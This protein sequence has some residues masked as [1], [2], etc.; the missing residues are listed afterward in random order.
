MFPATATGPG[1]GM[2]IACVA[3]RPIASPVSIVM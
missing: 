2:T 3:I 1:V